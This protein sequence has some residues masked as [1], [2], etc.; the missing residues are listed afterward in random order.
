[1][2]PK[3][4]N[5]SEP[6]LALQKPLEEYIAFF[7]NMSPRS[8]VFIRNLGDLGMHFR[9]PFHDVW[10]LDEVEKILEKKANTTPRIRY[11]LK[12]YGWASSDAYTVYLRWSVS[13]EEKGRSHEM[14]S[15]SEIVFSREG[16]V[17]AHIEHWDAGEH[18]YERLPVLGP[19]LRRIKKRL[20]LKA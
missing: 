20:A 18:V 15:M 9:D 4:Q 11:R 12:D 19:L 1:M 3:I 7:E 14:D 17:M 16:K 8:T 10:G 2:H 5:S 13:F 6:R